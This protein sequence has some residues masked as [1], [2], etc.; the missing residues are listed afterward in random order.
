MVQHLHYFEPPTSAD[1]FAS[2]TT[3]KVMESQQVFDLHTEP[4]V[5][6][7]VDKLNAIHPVYVIPHRSV[8]LMREWAQG[9][10]MAWRT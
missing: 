10:G 7:D 8:V 3:W 5:F 1:Q 9:L 4:R 2:A 6:E